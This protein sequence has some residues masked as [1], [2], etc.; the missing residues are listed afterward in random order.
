MSKEVEWGRRLG[1]VYL[2]FI[3]G[4][5][6]SLDGGGVGLRDI[7]L[8]LRLFISINGGLVGKSNVEDRKEYGSKRC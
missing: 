2:D 6:G 4:K 5:M 7:R 3:L 8:D 1:L